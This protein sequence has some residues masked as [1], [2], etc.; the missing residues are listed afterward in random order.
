MKEITAD[1]ESVIKQ[2]ILS[3]V[4][5]VNE[6]G[7]PNLSP[8]ASLTVVNGVLYFADIA[9]PRTILNLKRNPAVEI[10][11]VDVF[12]RRGY[13]FTGRASVLAPDDD[14]SL[15]IANWVRATNGPEYPVDHVVRIDT[16]AITPLLSPAHVFAQPPRDQEEIKSTYHQ[17]YGVKPIGE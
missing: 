1:M 9:P 4:A 7:T 17:K 15:M 16:T 10:N 3:F 13:R 12:Q 8:K 6:D 5:T 14:E 2:A 11:V